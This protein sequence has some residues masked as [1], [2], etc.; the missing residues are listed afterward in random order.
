MTHPWLL[1]RPVASSVI[2]PTPLPFWNRAVFFDWH[3]VLSVAPF[4]FSYYRL[5]RRHRVGIEIIRESQRIFRD[6]D[7]LND[8][9]R[10]VV[11]SDVVASRMVVHAKDA[12]MRQNPILH[13]LYEDCYRMPLVNAVLE[14]ASQA[15]QRAQVAIATDNMDC[16]LAAARH[17]SDLRGRFDG[18]LCSSESGVL[19]AEDPGAFF[20][21]WLEERGLDFSS[22]LLVDD[23]VHNCRA[24]EAHGGHAV[25]FV[26]D[27]AVERA[28]R[29]VEQ[30]LIAGAAT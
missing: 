25:H 17:R 11:S 6:E 22:A 18:L 4:W 12:R 28:R 9:M 30:F 15:R 13:R 16:F 26:G 20:G 21:E 5:R 27:D 2:E 14:I 3:G 7:L 19:K 29:A 1:D 10:G 24:F 8:W 23:G